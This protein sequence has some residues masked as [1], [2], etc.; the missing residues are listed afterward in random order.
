M[1]AKNRVRR[2]G[3]PD[4][5]PAGA[6]VLIG[7]ASGLS[8]VNFAFFFL[9]PLAWFM[10]QSR[11]AAFLAVLA[12]YMTV[13]SGIIAGTRLY[14]SLGAGFEAARY[15]LLLWC[16]TSLSLSAPWA[17][18]W[19]GSDSSAL[20]KTF[21]IV[22]ILVLVTV[23]PLGLWGWAN[24]L[25]CAG[26]LMPNAGIAGIVIIPAIWIALWHCRERH[27]RAFRAALF[28]LVLYAAFMSPMSRHEVKKPE[29]WEG[30]NT[31][32]G[33]LYSG[34]DDSISPFLRYQF[35]SVILEKSPAK[36]AVLPE[37]V[38]GWW[39]RTTEALWQPTTDLFR[40]RGKTYFTGAETTK[41]GT[42]KY[43]NVVQIRG[44]NND[45]VV[46]RFPVPFSMWKPWSDDGAVADWFGSNGI[47]TIDGM[48]VG[49]LICF[50]PY[51]YFPFL[52]T[53][54]NGPDII[55]VV[56]NSWWS[57]TTNLP[58]MS[59]KCAASWSILFGTPLVLS[60]N[61]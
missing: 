15:L 59:D 29:N 19:T 7:A 1:N 10:S 57:R 43:Y 33:R 34:S 22:V 25:L 42:K 32:F 56:S 46:Q 3:L 51:L 21:R 53:M 31:S 5:M 11:L 16:G 49:L 45:T 58:A 39:G 18:L 44:A 54:L 4:A 28:P 23:P 27:P 13:S 20:S 12:Y 38:S 50:E 6:A 8:Q 14:F 47:V 48:S 35:L 24:P 17:L 9:L 30:I 26:F 60:K 41:A 61:I 55:V 36:Y 37:T 2:F 40:S 52:V